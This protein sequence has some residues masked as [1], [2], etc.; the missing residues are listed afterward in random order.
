MIYDENEEDYGKYYEKWEI[1][2]RNIL[3]NYREKPEYMSQTIKMIQLVIDCHL[4]TF[5][6][7]NDR[8]IFKEIYLK[9]HDDPEGD[10]PSDKKVK[11]QK[12]G[13]IEIF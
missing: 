4:P 12:E 13:E 3:E 7:K 10:K 8:V 6:T 11:N 1:A 9:D 2:I 5:I